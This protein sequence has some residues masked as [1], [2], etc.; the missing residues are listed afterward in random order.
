MASRI[1]GAAAFAESGAEGA[2]RVVLIRVPVVAISL[3]IRFTMPA[4]RA[5]LKRVKNRCDVWPISAHVQADRIARARTLNVATLSYASTCPAVSH[6]RDDAGDASPYVSS[7][8]STAVRA[9]RQAAQRPAPEPARA[10]RARAAYYRT[11]ARSGLLRNGTFATSGRT[12]RL[13]RSRRRPRG[14]LKTSWILL[15]NEPVRIPVSCQRID[16]ISRSGPLALLSISGNAREP[17]NS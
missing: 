7:W 9:V 16:H 1:S 15:L 2:G 14:K 5:N 3:R 4:V 11:A 13:P 8:F 10:A 17:G 12:R 6:V